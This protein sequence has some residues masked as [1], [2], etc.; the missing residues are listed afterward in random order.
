MPYAAFEQDREYLTEKFR[1]PVFEPGVGLEN[2]TVQAGV[3]A[4]AESL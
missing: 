4:L 1:H 3:M 2:E